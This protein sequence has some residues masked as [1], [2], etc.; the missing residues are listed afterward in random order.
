MGEAIVC[1]GCS[2]RVTVGDG[3]VGKRGTQSRFRTSRPLAAAGCA[4]RNLP[5]RMM[6][7]DGLGVMVCRNE[8]QFLRLI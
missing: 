2:G 8:R 4:A 6:T 7:D 5:E 1:G 3:G